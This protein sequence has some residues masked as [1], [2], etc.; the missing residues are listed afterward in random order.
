M[1]CIFCNDST[2]LGIP[3]LEPYFKIK[4]LLQRQDVKV[5]SSNYALYADMSQ[6]V[7]QTLKT[8]SPNT[9]IYSIDEAFL[10]ITGFTQPL[11]EYGQQIRK[12]V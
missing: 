4:H 11:N 9:E 2:N 6:R 5:F 3:D 12:T 7:M 1:H 10:N 8:F